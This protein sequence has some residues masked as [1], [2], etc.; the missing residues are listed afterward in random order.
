MSIRQ[1][2]LELGMRFT[3]LQECPTGLVDEDAFKLIFAQFFPQGGKPLN[4]YGKKKDNTHKAYV[5]WHVCAVSG[6][7]GR[8]R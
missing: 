4:M 5:A 7:Q 8:K 3:M 2:Q 1:H 6:T